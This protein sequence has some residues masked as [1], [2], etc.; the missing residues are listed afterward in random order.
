MNEGIT[1]ILYPVRDLSQA[2]KL[3]NKLLGVQPMVDEAYYVGYKI[4]TQ[5]IGLVPNGF[6][7]GMSGATAYYQVSDI[8]QSLQVIQEEGGQV[9]QPAR[10]VGGGKLVAS[11]KDI[12]GNMVG[13][14]Q[15]P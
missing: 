9:V 10:D 14:I 4:G 7:Q 3:Y 13:F 12:D 2:K 5:D 11:T 15:M 1:T 8:Q 6:E